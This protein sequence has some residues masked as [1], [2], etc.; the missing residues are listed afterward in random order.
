MIIVKNRELLIP[1]NERYI[2]TNYDAGMEN[3]LFRVPRYSQSGT[4]LSDLTFKI[5]LIFEGDPLDRAEMTKAV[6]DDYIYL[7]WT[8]TEAQVA[9]TGTIFVCV[10]GNDTNDSVKWSS[11]QAPFYTEKSLGDDIDTAYHNLVNKVAKEITDRESAVSA[12]KSAREAADTT[13]QQNINAEASARAAGDAAV[14]TRIDNIVAQS[15]DD[16][17]EI[18]DARTG[19]DST[20]YASLK[21]RLD[22][23]HTDLK[24]AISTTETDVYYTE[25]NLTRYQGAAGNSGG[26]IRLTATGD[27]RCAFCDVIPGRSYKVQTNS[28]GSSYYG[29][30]FTDEN[31]AIIDEQYKPGVSSIFAV[32]GVIIAPPLSAKMYVN[33]RSA[34][35]YPFIR[36]ASYVG[37]LIGAEVNR[38][39][40]VEFTAQSGLYENSNGHISPV[41]SASYERTVVPCRAGDLYEI[42]LN[43]HS[44]FHSYTNK[45]IYLTDFYGS[46]LESYCQYAANGAVTT[47]VFVNNPNARYIYINSYGRGNIGVTKTEMPYMRMDAE[48][49]L[50]TF[51]AKK[52][53]LTNVG[54][55]INIVSASTKLDYDAFPVEL[56]DRYIIT[57]DQVESAN[58]PYY[59]F[60]TDENGVIL[61]SILPYGG[62]AGMVSCELFV[63][64]KNA[65]I[66]YITTAKELANVSVVKSVPFWT[67]EIKELQNAVKNDFSSVLDRARYKVFE[68][69]EDEV[70][71][72]FTFVTDTH[73]NGELDGA[74]VSAEN[75]LKAYSLMSNEKWADFAVHGGDVYSAYDMT[76]EDVAALL[77]E[78]ALKVG[79]IEIP[80]YWVKGNHELNLKNGVG[81]F[82]TNNQ[83]FLAAQNRLIGSV[84]VNPDDPYGGYF[85]RDCKGIRVIALNTWINSTETEQSGM[86]E[87]EDSWLESVL[88]GA[89]QNNLPVLVF[90]HNP[91]L[92][93]GNRVYVLLH[94]FQNDGG[95]VIAL[96]HGHTHTDDY[97]DEY[98][99]NMIGVR[100][101]FGY[102]SEFDTNDEYCFS[103]FTVNLTTGKL[104]ETRIG[105]GTDR[106]FDF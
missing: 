18:V 15:G 47:D 63:M 58:F 78:T 68:L 49:E 29:V 86:S 92:S 26:S 96:I 69:N 76:D 59:G 41:N 25:P 70:C 104:N 24:N 83:F 14:N 53:G 84:V 46:I 33:N 77:D 36:E 20:V 31:G 48:K 23:E 6:D 44:T 45:Y 57:V 17:T 9:V 79:G 4:D 38:R 19:A 21:A 51:K 61:Q 93:T 80:F 40:I 28:Y 30:T 91:I 90:M 56:N 52:G 101:G 99:F 74:V 85:Y 54:G 65:K 103:V 3:R 22:S 27:W 82:F 67:K 43:T 73:F 102:L 62:N 89:S 2:G 37:D 16:I 95:R 8:V 72:N 71:M 34:D 12:E 39:V 42:T 81:N 87:V 100:R 13:L 97:S 5:N 64:Q 35:T 60:I 1:E 88:D 75:N 10:T 98:G 32:D 55:S 105:S 50:L 7:T 11:F 106:S 94:A 66:L